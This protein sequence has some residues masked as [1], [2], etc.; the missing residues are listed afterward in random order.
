MKLNLYK[1]VAGNA[2]VEYGK[3]SY[4]ELDDSSAKHPEV[5][6]DIWT[7]AKKG[8]ISSKKLIDKFPANDIVDYTHSHPFRNSYDQDGNFNHSMQIPSLPDK[9]FY[10]TLINHVNTSNSIAKDNPDIPIRSIPTTHI[11]H[12]WSNDTSLTPY[13]NKFDDSTEISN[14]ILTDYTNSLKKA[15]EKQ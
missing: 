8:S 11:Y 4:T 10:K 1:L 13:T 5:K 3:L 2:D 7:E 6:H 15:T 14:E 9:N 12:P